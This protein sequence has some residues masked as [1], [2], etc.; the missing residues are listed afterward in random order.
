[1]VNEDQN[2]GATPQRPKQGGPLWRPAFSPVT[3]AAQ[4]WGC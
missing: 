3:Q 2:V 4:Q 1:M